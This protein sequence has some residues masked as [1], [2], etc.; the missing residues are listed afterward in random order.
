MR[1]PDMIR[2]HIINHAVH[3]FNTRGFA[4]TSVQDIMQATGLPKGAIYR[5]FE[6]KEGIVLAAFERS[7]QILQ[8]FFIQAQAEGTSA[9]D[10]L[11][12][13][14]AIY[15][16]AVDN[17]P[18]PGGCPLLNTAVESDG[19]FPELREKA[20]E[21]YGGM[22]MFVRSIIEQGIANKEFSAELDAAEMASFLI[23]SMEGAIMASRLT[24]SNAPVERNM[25][26]TEKLLRSYMI[27]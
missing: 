13:I 25:K 14:S 26:Y 5:R 4:Q 21:A 22:V 6:T 19:T 10:K 16:D 18:I 8:Q 11:M 7:G 12:K 20:A 1:K 24:G 2:D 17:P 3:L 9:L 15:Q 23:D 27:M